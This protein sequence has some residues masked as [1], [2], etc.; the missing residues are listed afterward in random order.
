MVIWDGEVVDT[1]STRG[2]RQLDD[3]YPGVLAQ[4]LQRLVEG[5]REGARV[6]IDEIRFVPEPKRVERWPATSVVARV[7]ARDCY[8]CRYCGEKTILTA[9]MRL[10]SRL[11]PDEFPM[12]RNW[13]ADETHPAFVARSATLDHVVP[14]AG[15]G[16]PL[17]ETNLVTACWGC[18]RRKG[19]L[20]LD[21]LGWHLRDPADR[22]WR[23]LT[24]LYEPAWI[25]SGRPV[26]SETERSWLLATRVRA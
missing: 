9:V 22:A 15:G 18:N 16:D 20:T 11:F 24:E 25:A 19:D 4:A 12:H 23:G 1:A 26:L 6:V 8:H 10:V 7:Y 2:P 17:D 21:E 14:I 3:P 5:D 13:K